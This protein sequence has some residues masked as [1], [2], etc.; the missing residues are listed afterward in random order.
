MLSSIGQEDTINP[1]N[2][3]K[4]Q[5]EEAF[6]QFKHSEA[7]RVKRNAERMRKFKQSQKQR[8]K[9]AYVNAAMTIVSGVAKG[10]ANAPV[11]K[12]LN[13]VGGKMLVSTGFGAIMGGKEGAIMGAIG[14]LSAGVIGKMEQKA[15]LQQQ[16]KAD[17]MLK[18]KIFDIQADPKFNEKL[19]NWKRQKGMITNLDSV[20][21]DQSDTRIPK[22]LYKDLVKMRD[23]YKSMP[24]GSNMDTYQFP[25]KKTAKEKWGGAWQGIK[26]FPGKLGKGAFDWT[27]G[28]KG[29]GTGGFWGN[30][31]SDLFSNPFGNSRGGIIRRAMGGPIPVLGGSTNLMQMV[32]REDQMTQAG[33]P[34]TDIGLSAGPMSK[35]SAGGENAFSRGGSFGRKLI[36][37]KDTVP[38]FLANGEYVLSPGTVAA[39]GGEKAQTF[40]TTETWQGLCRRWAG[41]KINSPRMVVQFV[42]MH[43][44][45]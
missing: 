25:K 30:P 26:E 23:Q 18:R 22:S 1:Q 39:I 15:Q 27:F 34:S 6:Y 5:R 9:A 38:G 11:G 4:F 42:V 8:M 32:P 10:Y 40:L 37:G 28:E 41:T 33:L 31:G 35:L 3:K 45:G 2:Q 12:F 29:P 7:M 44:V 19:N 21:G 43:R 24:A 20:I 16:M 17:E 13:S 36:G 14:G